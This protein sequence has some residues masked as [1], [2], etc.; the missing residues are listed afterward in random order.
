MLGICVVNLSILWIMKWERINGHNNILTR[1][2][3]C[4]NG[5]GNLVLLISHCRFTMGFFDRLTNILGLRKKVCADDFPDFGD[6]FFCLNRRAAFLSMSN[7]QGYVPIQGVQHA[8]RGP[9]Q[10]RKVD[11]P[12]PLHAGGAEASRHC[13][14]SWL[15]RGKIQK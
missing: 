8:C 4:K 5:L 6:K 2:R 13:P 12:E 10:L 9:R 11:H 14:H 15:Q 7:K 1:M 3:K